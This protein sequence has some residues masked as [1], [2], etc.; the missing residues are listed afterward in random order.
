MSKKAK[1][2][3]AIVILLILIG[4]IYYIMK[5]SASATQTTTTKTQTTGLSGILQGGLGNSLINAAVN[6]GGSTANN[7]NSAV[8]NTP[9]AS[10]QE[11][12]TYYG[13]GDNT[14]QD[15][16]ITDPNSN[17]PTGYD[18]N[19]DPYGNGWVPMNF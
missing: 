10:A 6:S 16:V 17:A 14:T 4:I 15:L 9:Y 5:G 2:I 12:A 1:V 11:T 8:P 7:S 19:G 18:E 13:A 3:I